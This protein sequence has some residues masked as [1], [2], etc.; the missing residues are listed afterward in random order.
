MGGAK[1]RSAEARIAPSSN[2]IRSTA[3]SL[4]LERWGY[5]TNSHDFWRALSPLATR[6]SR[7][8]HDS[9]GYG[10]RNG[11]DTLLRYTDRVGIPELTSKR[12]AARLRFLHVN[13]RH[14][15]FRPSTHRI[16]TVG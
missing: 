9:A 2:M 4:G 8:R 1:E 16:L 11:C 12:D 7:Q 15:S 10:N 3:V 6:L 13:D 5:D 14:Y